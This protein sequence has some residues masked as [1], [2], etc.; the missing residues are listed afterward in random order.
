MASFKSALNFSLYGAALMAAVNVMGAS[1]AVAQGNAYPAPIVIQS[2]RHVQPDAVWDHERAGRAAQMNSTTSVGSTQG[3]GNAAASTN[4]TGLNVRVNDALLAQPGTMVTNGEPSCPAQAV[5]WTVGGVTCNAASPVIISRESASVS[6]ID[7]PSTGSAVL[8]CNSGALSVQ[9]GS[10][11]SSSCAAG[12]VSWANGSSVCAANAP[13]MSAGASLGVASTNGVAGSASL[14]CSA[15]G[16]RSI[17]SA[18]CTPPAPA[19][20]VFI[21]YTCCTEFK[22]QMNKAWA[23]PVPLSATGPATGPA[24]N[25][26]NQPYENAGYISIWKILS[27][28]MYFQYPPGAV[29]HSNLI[30]RIYYENCTVAVRR[31]GASNYVGISCVERPY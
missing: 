30:Q 28:N 18:S 16:V 14:F 11:C 21:W 29:V 4:A 8:A 6:D 17:S 22:G 1:D 2:N 19:R 5:N 9:P 7:A 26:M 23:A 10:T 3:S 12:P 31:Y 13:V 15:A 27:S 25:T 20:T 24:I